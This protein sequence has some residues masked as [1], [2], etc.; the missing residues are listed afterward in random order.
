MATTKITFSAQKD[1]TGYSI[2]AGSKTVKTPAGK[3]LKYPNKTMAEKTVAQMTDHGLDAPFYRLMSFARDMERQKLEQE[4]LEHF[5]TD[6]VCYFADAPADLVAWQQRHWQPV[7]DWAKQEGIA[8]VKTTQHTSPLTQPD[9]A[10]KA[11]SEHLASLTP[12][13]F[14]AAFIAGKLSSSVLTGLAFTKGYLSPQTAHAVA[15]ADELYQQKRY[16]EDAEL[17]KNLA[18]AQ[19]QLEQLAL[20]TGLAAN[21]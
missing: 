15:H 12:T 18:E 2:V 1:G 4:L 19:S 13:Q 20:F 7:L 3:P 16:G 14:V 21:G 9:E 6:L 11:L 5:D 8:P 17:T 10:K